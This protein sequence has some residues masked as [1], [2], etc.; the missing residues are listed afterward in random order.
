MD[1]SLINLAI[2]VPLAIIVEFFPAC[3]LLVILEDHQDIP[4]LKIFFSVALINLITIPAAWL[5][6]KVIINV[7]PEYSAMPVL[8]TELLVVA[9]EAFFYYKVFSLRAKDALLLAF[10][11]NLAS[12]IIG[13]IAFAYS[14][15][16]DPF[17]GVNGWG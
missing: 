12:Y 4:V 13:L 11:P 3:F 7:P 16:Y 15:P 9:A 6:L 8:L 1:L 14:E 5:F 17:G 2:A 10:I